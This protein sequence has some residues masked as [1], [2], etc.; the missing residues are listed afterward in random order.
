[1]AYDVINAMASLPLVCPLYNYQKAHALADFKHDADF[2]QLMAA[3]GRAANLLK[4]TE[5]K[6]DIDEKLFV[7]PAEGELYAALRA[8]SSKLLAALAKRNYLAA[9]RELAAVRPQL[10]AFFEAVL[11]MA[12]DEAVRANRLALLQMLVTM[13]SELGDLSALVNKG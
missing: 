1:M 11:V 6:A 8:A 5:A 7:E 10:D 3:Y 13:T 12:E 9:L 2:A 4:N